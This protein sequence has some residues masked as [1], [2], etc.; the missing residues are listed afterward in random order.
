MTQPTTRKGAGGL[1]LALLSAASFGMAGSLARSLS[2][3]GWSS[4][5]AIIVRIGVAALVLLVPA[6]VALRGRW[7]SLHKGAVTILVFGLFAA[8]CQVCYFNAIQ[9]LSVGVALLLEYLG[10][11]LVVGWLWLRHG[12]R[13]RRL[14]VIGAA[15]AMVGLALVIDTSAGARFDVAGMLWALGAAVGLAAYFVL[16]ADDSGDVP[17]GVVA[18]GGMGVGALALLVVGAIGLMPLEATF[19]E[20][21]LAGRSTS[22]LVPTIGL[23]LISAAIA[24]VAGIAA[25][26]RL[27]AKVASFIGLTE[28]MFAVL[29]AWFFLGELPSG[30][31]LAG[32]VG[33]VLGASL[34]RI[35][36]LSE[37]GRV[38][39]VADDE[40]VIEGDR[41]DRE[42]ATL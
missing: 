24:Y 14:T 27:G 13:P 29:F 2:D 23:S 25:A 28:V 32:G 20:V 22:W 21:T 39:A 37:S 3:A 33:I 5:A 15:V 4:S 41:D 34:V 26:R 9:H 40:A 30:I 10:T 12:Q 8:A 42:P 36:E 31:Q 6:I 7:A 17:P 16:S 11:I 35:D 19:G 38:A 18:C 1:V